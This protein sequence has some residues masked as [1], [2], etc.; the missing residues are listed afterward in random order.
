MRPLSLHSFAQPQTIHPQ[1]LTAA[2]ATVTQ[3]FPM[4]GRM[5]ERDTVASFFDPCEPVGLA[6]AFAAAFSGA[7]DSRCRLS[8]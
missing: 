7:S 3:L 5:S 6:L 2:V 4:A 1:N 8:T